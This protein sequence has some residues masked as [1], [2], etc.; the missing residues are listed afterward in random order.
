ME[1]SSPPAAQTFHV[2]DLDVG[3]ISGEVKSFTIF[4][5]DTFDRTP[6]E[7]KIVLHGRDQH[8]TVIVGQVEEISILK[9]AIA[10]TSKRNRTFE[11]TIE[12]DA[13]AKKVAIT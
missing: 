7:L 11:F 2:V 1:I 3:F 8:L 12:P 5:G 10:W 4:D 9:A 13:D 6:D